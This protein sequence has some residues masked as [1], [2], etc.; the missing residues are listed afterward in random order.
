MG[1][2]EDTFPSWAAEASEALAPVA[3]R[4]LGP[5]LAARRP[6]FDQFILNEYAR[7]PPARIGA[8]AG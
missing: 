1:F 8:A 2:G 6:L 4:L 7:R 5:E 3:G